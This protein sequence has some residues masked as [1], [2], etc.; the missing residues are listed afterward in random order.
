MF[1]R[2]AEDSGA[3]SFVHDGDDNSP[4]ANELVPRDLVDVGVFRRWN[5]VVARDV[6]G[7]GLCGGG[8]DHVLGRAAATCLGRP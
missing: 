4:A 2:R 5:D 1:A 3:K 6:E 7:R 8:V